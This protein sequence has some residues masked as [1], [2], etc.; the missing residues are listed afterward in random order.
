[1]VLDPGTGPSAAVPGPFGRERL[2]VPRVQREGSSF[3]CW[4]ER[5]SKRHRDPK[6]MPREV[7]RRTRV[8]TE[9]VG[10]SSG[11]NKTRGTR[12]YCGT[13]R[14]SP[15]RVCWQ[16]NRE[17]MGLLSGRAVGLVVLAA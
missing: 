13:G 5:S 15:E 6:R 2:I 12:A 16:E 14:G 1:M 11:E 4:A 7:T 17:E 3:W 9:Q 8:G 10:A